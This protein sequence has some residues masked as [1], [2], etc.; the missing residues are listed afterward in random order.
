MINLLI[1]YILLKDLYFIILII[2]IYFWI[3]KYVIKLICIVNLC[4]FILIL[5]FFDRIRSNEYGIKVCIFFFYM[6]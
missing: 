1:L 6:W 3:L 2:K 5:K 4:L